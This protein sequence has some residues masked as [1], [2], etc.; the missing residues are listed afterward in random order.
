MPK[1]TAT[2]AAMAVSPEFDSGPPSQFAAL[3][4]QTPDYSPFKTLF[5]FDWGPVFYRGRLDGSAKVLCIASDPGATERI[6]N[7]TL[8]G[9]AGQRVQGFLKKIGLTR[10]YVCLNAFAYA[11]IPSKAKDADVVLRASEHV[12]WRNRL[13][14]LAKGVHVAA[15]IAFGGEAQQAV[16]LWTG[17][18]NTP[19]LSLPHPSSRDP[20][21]LIDAWRASVVQLRPIVPPDADGIPY[22]PNYGP[23]FLETDYERIPARD[24]PFGVPIWFGDDAWLRKK[25]QNVEHSSV[26]RPKPD[27]RHTLIWKAPVT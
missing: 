20:K 26:N 8:V 10:S 5:W 11:L 3:F 13:Y 14:D 9:D 6:A 23:Q 1:H 7:R 19:V 24:L 18:G 25:S 27:D 22:P 12:T 16:N 4:A 17:K 15:I 21:K 2:A